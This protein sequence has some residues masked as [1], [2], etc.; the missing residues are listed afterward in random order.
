ML[1]LGLSLAFSAAG[2]FQ[3]ERQ[4]GALEL[5]LVTP[6]SVG[7][8]IW[9]RLCGLWGQFLPALAVMGTIWMFLCSQG[10]MFDFWPHYYGLDV[11]LNY[12]FFTFLLASFAAIP[13]VGLYFSL[14]RRHFLAAWLLTL[15]LCLALPWGVIVTAG[16]YSNFLNQ[17]NAGAEWRLGETLAW[18]SFFQVL[19]ALRAGWLLYQ[20]LRRRE[21]AQ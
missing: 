21:F 1:L 7:Q 18:A 19:W 14:Q 15:A 4:N 2:S 6:L 17:N 5:I 12:A 13:V 8:I 16:W 11:Y 9:G 10:G 3:R 20:N